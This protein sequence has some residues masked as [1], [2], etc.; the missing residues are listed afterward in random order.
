MRGSRNRL[1]EEISAL[2][3]D[4]SKHGEKAIA[5]VRRLRMHGGPS[6]GAPKSNK[7]AKC[8]S[9]PG[10]G[11]V[12]EA[13]QVLGARRRPSKTTASKFLEIEP[14]KWSFSHASPLSRR[15]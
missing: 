1:S 11:K 2:L 12:S 6:P 15:S 7:C 4:F 13:D 14:L 8:S 5:K 9:L 10:G 3:R